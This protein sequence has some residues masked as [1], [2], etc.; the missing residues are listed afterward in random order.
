MATALVASICLRWVAPFPVSGPA[1][2]A[3][4]ALTTTVVTTL[5]WLVVTFATKAEPEP[6][7]LAFIERSP[8]CCGMEADRATRARGPSDA[9]S[10]TNLLSWVSGL[11]DGIPRAVRPGPHSD[12]TLPEGMLL[13]VGSASVRAS[14]STSNLCT[15]KVGEV[16]E[17]RSPVTATDSLTRWRLSN[18]RPSQRC[19][20]PD[21]SEYDFT[22]YRKLSVGRSATNT[23]KPV[24]RVCVSCDVLPA[25]KTP[26]HRGGSGQPRRSF[27]PRGMV[28]HLLL[29]R[30]PK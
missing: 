5:V 10:G 4:T 27:L 22:P 20:S 7:L 26:V 24:S 8:A 23:P 14:H 29:K 9:R 28:R 16:K 6:I 21:K 11:R 3:K 30:H 19:S 15:R 12:R 25:I 1:V 17:A 18:S 13:L 2:F